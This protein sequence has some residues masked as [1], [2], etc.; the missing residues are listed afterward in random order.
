MTLE[1]RA[2]QHFPNN[3]RYQEAWLRMVSILGDK[4]L[5]ARKVTSA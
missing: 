1:E 5:L 4:W 2:A 3:P